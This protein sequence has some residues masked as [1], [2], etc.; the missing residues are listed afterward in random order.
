MSP[1]TA[2]PEIPFRLLRAHRAAFERVRL[3]GFPARLSP[4]IFSSQAREALRFS[5]FPPMISPIQINGIER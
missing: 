4:P 3:F 2:G 1:I 5:E